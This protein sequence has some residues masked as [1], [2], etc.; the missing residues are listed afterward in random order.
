[1]DRKHFA[2]SRGPESSIGIGNLAPRTKETKLVEYGRPVGLARVVRTVWRNRSA[3]V[4]SLVLFSVL[5]AAIFAPW[6]APMDPTHI[7]LSKYLSPPVWQSGGTREHLLGTDHLGRDVFSRM[8]YGARVSMLVSFF[9]VIIS[10][11]LGVSLGMISGYFGGR[12]DDLIMGMAQIQQSFPF[13][14]LAIAVVAVLGP[15]LENTI[16]VLGVSGWV[17]FARLVRGEV[18]TV[19]EEEYIEAARTVGAGSLRIMFRHILPNI[20]S[21]LI[22]MASFVFALMIVVEASLSFIGLGVQPPDASWGLMLSEA[23]NYLESAWWLPTFPG[24][25][26]V[27]TVLGANLLG[28][29]L[30]DTLDPRLRDV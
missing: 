14:A 1:M 6:I 24:M 20:S 17:L 15:G 21:P 9:T 3:V 13:I 2:D 8:L 30:R 25:A 27:M 4:G 23:R 11:G 12:I 5:L 22:V 26:I 10:G 28:D 19:R 7:D 29:W 16:L 18:L